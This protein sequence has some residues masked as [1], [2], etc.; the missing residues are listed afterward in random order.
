MKRKRLYLAIQSIVC[1]LLALLL[2]AAVVDACRDG[3]AARA[4]DPLAPIFS[5]EIAAERLLPLA[6]LFFAAAALTA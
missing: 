5:R 6:P 2:I 1:I 3:M 4:E